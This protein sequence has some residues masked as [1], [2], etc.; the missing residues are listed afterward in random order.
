[1]MK[2]YT[3]EAWLSLFGGSPS[4]VIDDNGYIYS[5]DGYYKIISDSP[6]GKIDYA[7]GHIYDKHYTDLW[8]TPIA[9][10]TDDGGVIKVRE[11]GKSQF[12]DPIL[13]IQGD[14]IYTPQEYLRIFGGN[15]SGYIKR[16]HDT[17]A[18][19][20]SSGSE[21][22]SYSS[23][24]SAGSSSSGSSGG[25]APMPPFAG[26]LGVALM[27][28]IIYLLSSEARVAGLTVV[29]A[30]LANVGAGIYLLWQV[31]QGKLHFEWD[32]KRFGKAL[33]VGIGVY[34]GA[35][36]LFVILGLISN[37]GT[38]HAISDGGGNTMEL[39]ALFLG[40]PF[41]VRGLFAEGAKPGAAKGS[42]TTYAPPRASSP[43][44]PPKSAP[45]PTPRYTPNPGPQPQPTGTRMMFCPYCRT[46]TRVPAGKG[47]IRVS[48]PNPAC[49]KKYDVYS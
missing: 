36:A 27:V 35:T 10:M 15:A 12:S 6:I 38:G 43:T 4:L 7:K 44:A 16:D 48:C 41:V 22:Y 37:L 23:S 28:G 32:G 47:K 40:I 46:K 20:G 21:G 17:K 9:Y 42:G 30:I 2:I 3:P 8:P 1:M 34:V 18:S 31:T 13:Y 26:V 29:V 33:A 19:S 24:G 39:A 11:Y 25:G 14:K 5:A 45:Q 49:C